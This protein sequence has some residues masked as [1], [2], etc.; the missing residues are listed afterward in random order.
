MPKASSSAVRRPTRGRPPAA[1]KT[2]SIGVRLDDE[3]IAKID[4]F[5]PVLRQSLGRDLGRSLTLDRSDA[6]RA[7]IARGL[8]CTCV[9]KGS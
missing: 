5:I 7:L 4:G 8:S 6:L 3:T 1:V 2:R 9:G